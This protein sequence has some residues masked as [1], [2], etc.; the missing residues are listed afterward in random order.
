MQIADGLG[1]RFEFE[2]RNCEIAIFSQTKPNVIWKMNDDEANEKRREAILFDDIETVKSFIANGSIDGTA[3]P[4]I[5]AAGYGRLEIM[6]LLLDAGV[7]IDVVDANQWRGRTAC[8]AAAHS[9]HVDALKLLLERGATVNVIRS[10]EDTLLNAVAS[11]DDDEMAILL[12]DAGAPLDHVT[13]ENL[14]DLVAQSKS[15][16]VLK[17]LLA[18]NA[19]FSALR[20]SHGLSLFHRVVRSSA[21]DRDISDLLRAI[22]GAARVDV[23]AVNSDGQTPLHI[24]AAQFNA[25]LLRILVEVGADIDLRDPG[26]LTPLH[27]ACG[28]MWRFDNDSAEMLIALG[29]DVHLVDK[30]GMTACHSAAAQWRCTTSFAAFVAAGCDLDQPDNKGD[31]PRKLWAEATAPKVRPPPTDAEI[32]A[33]RK[34]LTKI[35]LDSVLDRALQV[36]IGL[37]PL[38]L[39]AL[40]LC[41]IMMRSC[42]ALGSLIMFHQWWK[43]ATTVKHFRQ[44]MT[45]D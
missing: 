17:R 35:R 44:E 10:E 39:D 21:V 4:L 20:D 33:A 8:H 15:V 7:D 26:G 22:A 32:A 3:P 34:R 12:L 27:Q 30:D 1:L 28:M 42:G 43:I 2:L 38:H 36:C 29:A 45:N 19:N 18:R 13:D 37:Q 16:A 14:L 5:E 41:E 24:A 23:N 40:V 6:T 11:S 9:G 31:T 25:A